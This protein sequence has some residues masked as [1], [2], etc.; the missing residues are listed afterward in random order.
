MYV[1]LSVHKEL[2]AGNDWG[3][4]PV[5]VITS[6]LFPLVSGALGVTSIVPGSAGFCT[7][8]PYVITAD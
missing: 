8:L 5:Q 1:K 7:K 2:P 3:D 6:F 4:E